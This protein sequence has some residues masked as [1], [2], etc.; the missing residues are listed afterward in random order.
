MAAH[1][2]E[3]FRI[4]TVERIHRI[5][6]QERANALERT[7]YN[8]FGLTMPEV[9]ID[10]LTDSG[11]GAM[12][13][14]Q[15]ADIMLADET[16]AGARSFERLEQAFHDIFGFRHLIPTHQGRAAENILCALLVKEGDV[17]P[18]NAHFDTTQANV[19]A[20]GGRPADLTIA[21]A[22]DPAAEHAF[23]GNMDIVKLEALIDEVGA[24]RIPFGMMTITNNAVG[25]QPV[26]MENLKQASQVYRRHK[27]PFIID[28]CRHAE[29]AYFIQQRE[30]GYQDKPVL[31]IARQTFGLA[32]GMTMSG[33]KDGLS[34]IGGF[35]GFNDPELYERAAGELV[36]REG[37]LTYG[38]MSGR[39]MEAMATGLYEAL[40]EQYLAYRTGQTRYLGERIASLGVPI[41]QPV[42]GHAVYVDAGGLLPHIPAQ[43]FPGQSLSVSLYLEGG[44][45]GVELG[46]VA[47]AHEDPET[48]EIHR[49]PLELVR[50]AIP[51]R[52]YTQSH[53]D[54]IVEAFER[55]MATCDSLPGYR[56]VEAPRLLRHFLAKFEPIRS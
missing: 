37:F 24:D 28:G 51:R 13:D 48:R 53:M 19:L 43:S 36:L 11:T 15:W 3:P 44:I 46:S 23:K 49:P 12:S 27:I 14:Q 16:Y 47:F 38:G 55:V 52:M 1:P 20:R 34:N 7:H 10:L 4:K 50:L 18:S 2:P 26:S 22:S 31:E 56:I 54:V 6:R 42:G 29:N 17:I 9:Y 45:R 25:G 21:E 8:L 35:L 41:I 40:D 5:T 32:D 39:A 30:P 33:K